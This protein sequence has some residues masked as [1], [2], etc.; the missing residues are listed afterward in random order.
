M[1]NTT[2]IRS[3]TEQPITTSTSI[4]HE[5]G[6]MVDIF[7][8]NPPNGNGDRLVRVCDH[9]MTLMRLSYSYD[10]DTPKKEEIFNT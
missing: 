9:G 7:L 3:M 5:D 6:D 10:L 8:E 2:R 4:Y 1:A